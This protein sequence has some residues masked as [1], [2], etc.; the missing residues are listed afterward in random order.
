MSG[1]GLNA[2][3]YLGNS[4]LQVASLQTEI[5]GQNLSNSSNPSASRQE[6]AETDSVTVVIGG[7]DLN[8]GVYS[9]GIIGTRSPYLDQQ[10]QQENSNLG[11]AN[12]VNSFETGAQN[13][14]SETLTEAQLTA[15]QTA[16][17]TGLEAASS[18][19]YNAWGS[20]ASDPTSTSQRDALS[21]AAQTFVG[22]AQSIYSQIL[23]T[24]QGLFTEAGTEV[25][26]VNQLTSQI[27]QLNQSIAAASVAAAVTNGT[28]INQANNLIDQRQGLVE[29]LAT[30]VNINV[31]TDTT[32]PA[33]IDV[34]LAD[35][36]PASGSQTATTPPSVTNPSTPTTVA[37]VTGVYGGGTGTGSNATYAISVNGADPSDDISGYAAGNN[38]SLIATNGSG[39]TATSLQVVPT[40]GIWAAW[41][42]STTT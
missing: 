15:G 34:T 27:A 39:A 25:S 29:Q 5:A 37:L 38:L 32:N 8:V 7:Q 30:L 28:P 18:A 11:Y 23:T 3:I 26:T 12:T 33:M 16:S 35:P 22:T 24:K 6:V 41:S 36:A 4:A 40:E 14:L 2:D 31:S 42:R 19:F 21:A 13:D 9:P 17:Q 20:L 10:M 1:I